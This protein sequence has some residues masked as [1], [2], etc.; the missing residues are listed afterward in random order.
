A[1]S[2]GSACRRL[3][4]IHH[5]RAEATGQSQSAVV[6]IADQAMWSGDALDCSEGDDR[7][8]QGHGDE[9]SR[10]GAHEASFKSN[11]CSTARSNCPLGGLLQRRNHTGDWFPLLAGFRPT[12][13]ASVVAL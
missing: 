11:C 8:E 12:P 4:V 9:N 2:G 6:G 7:S 3:G 10:L 13:N 5:D 1:N